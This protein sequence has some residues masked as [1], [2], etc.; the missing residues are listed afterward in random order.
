MHGT[1]NIKFTLIIFFLFPFWLFR[2]SS[3]IVECI[4]T[5]EADDDGPAE[6]VNFLGGSLLL[7]EAG[8]A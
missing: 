3:G 7:L 8:A 5:V 4:A 2:T 6:S 1:Y